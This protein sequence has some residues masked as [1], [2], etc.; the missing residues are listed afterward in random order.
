M[1]QTFTY[2]MLQRPDTQPYKN[3]SDLMHI[4]A[5]SMHVCSCKLSIHNAHINRT[6]I[7]CIRMC[8]LH[9]SF[10]LLN[11]IN[12]L[13]KHR[14]MCNTVTICL[15]NGMIR[16]FK[17]WNLIFE[18]ILIYKQILDGIQMWIYSMYICFSPNRNV[19][20]QLKQWHQE[21]WL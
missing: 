5:N 7:K 13:C 16:I 18:F 3:W 9:Y 21:D 17:S 11:V 8:T 12:L 15:Q 10:K 19:A 2:I 20:I 4:W 6:H 1:Q 14:M